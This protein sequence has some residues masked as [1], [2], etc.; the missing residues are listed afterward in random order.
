MKFWVGMVFVVMG[1]VLLCCLG[2]WQIKRLHWKEGL[3]AQIA[4]YEG[5]E[6]A[7]EEYVTD[8]GA[9]FRRGYLDGEWVGVG[10]NVNIGDSVGDGAGGTAGEGHG[11][12]KTKPRLFEGQIGYW[13]VSPFMTEG[14]Q[15]IFVNRGWVVDGQQARVLAH[16][17]PQ[18]RVRVFGAL[19]EHGALADYEAV[20]QGGQWV[21]FMSKAEPK[22]HAELVPAPVRATLRNEHRNYAIFWFSMAAILAGFGVFSFLKRRSA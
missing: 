8:E 3:I 13:I 6:V 18:G 2:T 7:L 21:L 16:E 15:R 5:E 14:G 10:E 4:A 20:R 19:R 9:A 11:T 17:L 22:D 1:V 12:F